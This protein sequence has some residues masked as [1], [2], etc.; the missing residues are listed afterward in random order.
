M[1]QPVGELGHIASQQHRQLPLAAPPVGHQQQAVGLATDLARTRETIHQFY[2][3]VVSQ[4]V[5]SLGDW[6]PDLTA[7]TR[8]GDP[9]G[10]EVS[11]I[12]PVSNEVQ[13]GE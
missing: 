4:D 13:A 8:I 1:L 12:L 10:S 5:R 3:Q 11:P 6:K 7:L 9:P 2:D